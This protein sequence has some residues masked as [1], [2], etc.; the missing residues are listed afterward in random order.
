MS[1]RQLSKVS[2]RSAEE[3]ELHE[4]EEDD[5]EEGLEVLAEDFAEANDDANDEQEEEDEQVLVQR[6]SIEVST[7]GA[8]MDTVENIAKQEEEEVKQKGDDGAFNDEETEVSADDLIASR[9]HSELAVSPRT[10]DPTPSGGEDGQLTVPPVAA[11][12][13]NATTNRRKKILRMARVMRKIQLQQ[14]S[15]FLALGFRASH[16]HFFQL[17]NPRAARQQDF[18]FAAAQSQPQR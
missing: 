1:K 13:T 10:H 2:H 3:P 17:L 12:V 5:E 11:V 7:I 15:V 16:L 9:D 14:L 18:M 8:S 4:V 6:D